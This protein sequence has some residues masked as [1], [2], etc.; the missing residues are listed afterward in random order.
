MDFTE[1]PKD[2]ECCPPV[3][4]QCNNRSCTETCCSLQKVSEK[5]KDPDVSQMF[6]KFGRPAE[7]NLLSLHVPQ[8]VWGSG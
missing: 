8:R 1:F 5:L 2:V 4:I 6:P 7:V 3:F